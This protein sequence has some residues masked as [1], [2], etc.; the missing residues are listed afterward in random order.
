MDV[1]QLDNFHSYFAQLKLSNL[2]LDLRKL[3]FRLM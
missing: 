1:S 3:D 2:L